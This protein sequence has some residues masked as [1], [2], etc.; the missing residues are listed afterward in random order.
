M[1]GAW[2]SRWGA[3]SSQCQDLKAKRN[4]HDL[5]EAQQ[6]SPP[7]AAQPS[8]P[9]SRTNTD[10]TITQNGN[11]PVQEKSARSPDA[12]VARRSARMRTIL[13]P[14]HTS[15]TP[16]LR[17]LLHHRIQ[18]LSSEAVNMADPPHRA[19][20]FPLLP[21]LPKE[22][23]VRETLGR[24]QASEQ[25]RQM[26]PLPAMQQ[27]QHYPSTP[28]NQQA[29]VPGRNLAPLP[30]RRSTVSFSG[31]NPVNPNSNNANHSSS[32]V[33][34]ASSSP[35]STS[36]SM[37]GV[38][39]SSRTGPTTQTQSADRDIVM[40]DLTSSP[41]NAPTTSATPATQRPLIRFD[42]T[43]HGGF[44]S[45]HHG[46][47][48]PLDG[49]ILNPYAVDY[50]ASFNPYA[51]ASPPAGLAAAYAAIGDAFPG[52]AQRRRA[53][54]VHQNLT[55]PGQQNPYQLGQQNPTQPGHQNS[56]Q[57]GPE[58]LAQAGQ[59]TPT[60]PQSPIRTGRRNPTDL[61]LLVDQDTEDIEA[62]R[63]LW[64]MSH[65][66][67]NPRE[68]PTASARP[69]TPA[70]QAQASTDALDAQIASGAQ[71]NE[72]AREAGVRQDILTATGPIYAALNRQNQNQGQTQ[73]QGQNTTTNFR[74][75]PAIN[76]GDDSANATPESRLRIENAHLRRELD[77][78]V[79][80]YE[81]VNQQFKDLQERYHQ[82][83]ESVTTL[84]DE[85]RAQDMVML[86][87]SH[88]LQN[89]Q[90]HQNQP[91]AQNQPA[92]QTQ[93]AAQTQP[94]QTPRVQA[95]NVQPPQPVQNQ[96]HQG[97]ETPNHQQQ[98]VQEVPTQ[99]TRNQFPGQGQFRINQPAQTQPHQ[100]L[101]RQNRPRQNHPG[102]QER[103]QK[104]QQD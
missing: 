32:N 51:V 13:D 45:G 66:M 76:P 62:S 52:A 23:A 36:S 37:D 31:F 92:V 44:R 21:P 85:M 98:Q 38:A 96:H 84:Q 60:E 82:S 99:H 79:A 81:L 56:A 61:R 80:R 97:Q 91:A 5:S 104:R 100:R 63:T 88:R 30:A 86:Q 41:S 67:I 50:P 12:K 75:L 53:Q 39:S 16:A 64:F 55:Q 20:N 18:A 71:S 90:L 57:P 74:R 83:L 2:K 9:A 54:T 48:F 94:A 43:S 1:L 72:P 3:I 8:P 11:F 7:Q 35:A 4:S 78:A 69:Q 70:A 24:E 89:S 17:Q 25:A 103:Q 102:Q 33:S 29:P 73:N 68:E 15:S 34:M 47:L 59:T 65:D 93:P 14:S 26:S 40:I 22:S 77:R 95:Q 6:H 42:S 46:A 19:N 49:G 10:A 27:T 101:P 58:N 28:T 87:W